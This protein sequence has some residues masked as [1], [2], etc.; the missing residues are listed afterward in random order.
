M[1]EFVDSGGRECVVNVFTNS[2]A[3]TDYQE[4]GVAESTFLTMEF[5]PTSRSVFESL[6]SKTGGWLRHS[7]GAPWI[8]MAT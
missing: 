4:L 6:V 5:G 2:Y 1:I 7:D 3:A 8:E